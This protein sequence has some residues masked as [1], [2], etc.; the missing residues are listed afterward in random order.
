MSPN[1]KETGVLAIGVDYDGA[2]HRAFSI[3]PLK[4]KDS[5][6]VR[7]GKD[8]AA[9][10][11]DNELMGLALLGS[12]ITIEGIPA[13]AQ[14]L[15]FMQDLYDDDLAE[16][17]AADGRLQEEIARF[18]GTAAKA[19]GAGAGAHQSS[20]GD[21]GGDVAGGGDGVAYRLDGNPG[22][23]SSG[24]APGAPAEES[25]ADTFGDDETANG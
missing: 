18:R 13:E 11:D 21:S 4:A 1:L 17:M 19:D 16:I 22:G 9:I 12:R 20:V 6:A 7:H 15:A 25:T 10:G 14:D 3:R 23:E 8:L 24:E 2:F 5:Y